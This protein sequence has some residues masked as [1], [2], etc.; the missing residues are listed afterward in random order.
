QIC[1]LDSLKDKAIGKKEKIKKKR[2]ISDL[3]E[4]IGKETFSRKLALTFIKEEGQSDIEKTE[5]NTIK[6]KPEFK[7]K[8]V[9]KKEE[10]KEK[11]YTVNELPKEDQGSEGMKDKDTKKIRQEDRLEPENKKV[12]FM[13]WNLPNRISKKQVTEM[14][15]KFGQPREIRILHSINNKTRAEVE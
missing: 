5:R 1:L 6:Q 14:I 8:G 4:N 9:I 15:K 12:Y 13:I 11:Q 3:L 2:Y 7:K 10:E